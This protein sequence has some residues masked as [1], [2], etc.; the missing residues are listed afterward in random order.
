MG[1]K[2]GRCLRLTTLPISCTVVM[3]SRN[4]NFLETSGH[5]G[6]VMGQ[7]YLYKWSKNGKKKSLVSSWKLL[8]SIKE[9]IFWP[10]ERENRVTTWSLLHVVG[11]VWL[12]N[13]CTAALELSEDK[14]MYCH[15][16]LLIPRHTYTVRH[17]AVN[18]SSH[19]ICIHLQTVT[20]Q[21]PLRLSVSL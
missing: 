3:K 19:L 18:N 21:K 12:Q 15:N 2:S 1:V 20:E 13:E 16:I 4:L 17:I 5:L 14:E 7:S 9:E 11:L 10:I 6:P 8:D